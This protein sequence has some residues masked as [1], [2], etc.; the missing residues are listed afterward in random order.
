MFVESPVL[1]LKQDDNG[2]E[3]HGSDASSEVI[4]EK[5]D[6]LIVNIIDSYY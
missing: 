5:Y 4:M 2:I 1:R 6:L 3:Y